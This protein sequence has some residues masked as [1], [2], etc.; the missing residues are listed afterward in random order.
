[1]THPNSTVSF[2]LNSVFINDNAFFAIE[3][4][5]LTNLPNIGRLTLLYLGYLPL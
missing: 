5:A 3:Y 2:N 1:M 4:A